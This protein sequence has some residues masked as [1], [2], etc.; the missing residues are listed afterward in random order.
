M[1]EVALVATN[2]DGYLFRFPRA[3]MTL[4]SADVTGRA[5][6][7]QVQM[8]VKAFRQTAPV[9]GDSARAIEIYRFQQP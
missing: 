7:I 4:A 9:T 2:G 5:T 1:F 8:T 3:K 6:T